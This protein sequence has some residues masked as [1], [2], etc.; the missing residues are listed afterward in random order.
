MKTK[1]L[2]PLIY[3]ED[4]RFYYFS[5]WRIPSSL[6]GKRGYQ[7]CMKTNCA[8]MTRVAITIDVTGIGSRGNHLPSFLMSKL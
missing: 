5:I 3:F 4:K 2:T 1:M 8:E 7:I 6:I